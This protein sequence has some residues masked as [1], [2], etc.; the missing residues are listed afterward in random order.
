MQALTC[1]TAVQP[2]GQARLQQILDKMGRADQ[3]LVT[4]WRGQK[5]VAMLIPKLPMGALVTLETFRE[6]FQAHVQ[7]LPPLQ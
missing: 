7:P 2:P 3:A 1:V 6:L 4:M 5:L